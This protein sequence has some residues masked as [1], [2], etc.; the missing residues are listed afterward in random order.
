MRF[1]RMR[2]KKARLWCSFKA[3][4]WTIAPDKTPFPETGQ[5]TTRICDGSHRSECGPTCAPGTL[6]RPR[7]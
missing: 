2:Y 7:P 5:P 6:V 1:G 3:I 4:A